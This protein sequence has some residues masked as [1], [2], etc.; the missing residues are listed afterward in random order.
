MVDN[1]YVRDFS[2][3]YARM[4]VDTSLAPMDLATEISQ[5]ELNLEIMGLSG[6]KIELKKK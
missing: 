1:V 3:G 4:D 5:S 6:S 2:G